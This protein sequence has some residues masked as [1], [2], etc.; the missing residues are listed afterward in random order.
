MDGRLPPRED[1]GRYTTKPRGIRM[2][3]PAKKPDNSEA[4]ERIAEL[5][6][7]ADRD[8]LDVAGPRS[9]T[10]GPGLARR[11]HSVKFN[12]PIWDSPGRRG[13]W[14]QSHSA[15]ILAGTSF[16]SGRRQ[17]VYTS[18]CGISYSAP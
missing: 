6:E 17:A 7:L 8:V 13:L 5:M 11:S 9:R 3:A 15:A 2:D 1:S 16:I 18:R 4:L 12:R 10:G 14:R